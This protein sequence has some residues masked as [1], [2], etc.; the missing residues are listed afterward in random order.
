MHLPCSQLEAHCNICFFGLGHAPEAHH[1]H[2]TSNPP[3]DQG[4]EGSPEETIALGTRDN[5]DDLKRVRRGVQ[6]DVHCAAHLVE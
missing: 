3:V 2:A 4:L 5:L 1:F 6:V